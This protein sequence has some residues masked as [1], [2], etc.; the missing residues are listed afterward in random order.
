[1]KV[2]RKLKVTNEEFYNT[3]YDSLKAEVE[4]VVKKPVPKLYSGYKYE[5]ELLTYAKNKRLVKVEITELVENQKYS[6]NFTS[7][8]DVNTVS[9][10]ITPEELGCI[11][12]YEEDFDNSSGLRRTN[13]SIMNFILTPYNK[14]RFKKKLKAMENFII[15]NR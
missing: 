4:L 2:K 8:S 12:E 1:M 7:G 15:E 10:T 11:V 3:L 5:K 13:F 9:F 14:R 6:A